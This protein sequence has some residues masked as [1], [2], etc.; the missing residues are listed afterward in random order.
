LCEGG[1]IVAEVEGPGANVAALPPAAVTRRLTA[2][3]SELG[4]IHPESC[5]AGAAGAEVP[6]GRG[7]LEKLLKALLPGCRIA[8]VHDA[9][10]VLSAAQTDEG[11]AL[12]SGTGSVAYGRTSD[13]REARVGGWGW[14]VGDDGSGAWITREAAREVMQRADSG[15]QVGELGSRLLAACRARDTV[16]L[17]GKLNRLREPMEWAA[18]ANVVFEAADLDPGAQSVV[19]RCASALSDLARSVQTSLRID[20]PVVLAGGLLLNQPRLECAVRE[21]LGAVCIRLEEPPVAGAVRLAEA[22]LK[23]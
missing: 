5:C 8:V 14:R 3:L 11:I 15:R 9:R 18:M 4:P 16:Q 22:E 17:L 23:S 2:L 21:Q 10:L 19:L 7:H 20:G 12:I 6:A 1:R 13:G